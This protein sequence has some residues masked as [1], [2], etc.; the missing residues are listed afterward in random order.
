MWVV[1]DAV[2]IDP[3]Y[4]QLEVADEL[5]RGGL[6]PVASGMA[7]HQGSAAIHIRNR[8]AALHV[9]RLGSDETVTLPDA[10]YLHVFVARGGADLEGAGRLGTGDAVRLAGEGGHRVTATE[11][12]ELLVWEMHAAIAA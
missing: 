2:G 9:A 7:Q 6:V 5:L 4:Q 10:P 3:G 11:P 12:S 8:Y 1:P